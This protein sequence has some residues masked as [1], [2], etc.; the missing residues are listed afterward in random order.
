MNRQR[1]DPTLR[2]TTVLTAVLLLGGCA[3]AAA[4]AWLPAKGEGYVSL[5]YTNV[6]ADKHYLP[7][8]RTDLGK[9]DSNTFFFDVTYGLTERVT[10]S[11]G[12]PLV[13]SRYRG[14]FPHQL[15]NPNRMDDGQWHTTSQ[16]IRFNVRYNILNGPLAVTPFI[17]TVMPSNAYE[18]WA[19]SAAGRHL[20]EVQIGVTAARRLDAI[21]AGLFMQGRYS[22]AFGERVLE[23]KM[24]HSN[25]DVEVGYFVS[26]AL[27]VFALGSAQLQH[28][29]IDI[30][31]AAIIAQ[32]LTVRQRQSHDRIGRENFLNVGVG[33]STRLTDRLDLFGSFA[34][35]VAGRNGHQIKH[36]VS[37]GVT[38]N[39]SRHDES[40]AAADRA[41]ENVVARC[42]C[43][44]GS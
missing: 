26:P 41:V 17:G 9:I 43:Q 31:P 8:E 16:D 4:Q 12:L 23:Y 38:W 14:R 39:F 40:W 42:V 34:K 13:M 20:R 18:T 29:G 11:A 44:K 2:R 19:H 3:N 7:T 6:F 28:D 36:A 10:V 37:I 24:N 35:Q 21:A 33:A 15:D 27:R 5:V 30:P 22:F 1:G 25:G 32:T